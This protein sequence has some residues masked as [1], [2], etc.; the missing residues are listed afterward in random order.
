MKKLLFTFLACLMTLSFVSCES[1]EF[2]SIITLGRS[3]ESSIVSSTEVT[4]TVTAKEID[5]LVY[6]EFAK[7]HEEAVQGTII[8]RAQSKESD[9]V[10]TAKE[11]ASRIEKKLSEKYGNP[12]DL[13]SDYKALSYTISYSFDTPNTKEIAKIVIR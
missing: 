11:I 3:F 7:G 4:G 12:I 10:N 5:Q 1:E 13:T 9:V 6:E 2:D 8:L